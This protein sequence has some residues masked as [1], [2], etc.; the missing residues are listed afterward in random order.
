MNANRETALTFRCSG[1][2][3]IGILHHAD[4]AS[5][6][7]IGVLIIVGGPQYRVGS[8]RQFVLMARQFAAA[9]FPVFRFDYRGMGD[10]TGSPR[11]FENVDEDIRA[12][13]G[14]FRSELPAIQGV[15]VFGLCDAAS[16]ALMYCCHHANIAGL[17]L[18]N[19]WARTDEG[20]ARVMVRHYYLPRLLQRSLWRKIVTRQFEPTEALRGAL[21][22]I[23]R[24]WQSGRG[25]SKAISQSFTQRMTQGVI[26]FKGPVLLL[27]SGRDLTAREFQ[28]FCARSPEWTTWLS[29]ERVTPVDLSEAD[30][31]F[32]VVTSLNRASDRVKL[33]LSALEAQLYAQRTP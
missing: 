30:H 26:T 29:S 31:T 9:G 6:S 33:W 16:A 27:L 24:A 15:V 18:A 14:V 21:A 13:I 4:Q 22:L 10:S 7:R 11:S 2:D 25:R 1:D 28:D 17:V 3:L 19:P 5:G 32:S 8:H 12:A 23:R 20:A